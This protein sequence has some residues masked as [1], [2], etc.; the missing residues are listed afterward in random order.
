MPTTVSVTQVQP[1]DLQDNPVAPVQVQVQQVPPVQVIPYQNIPVGS[2]LDVYNEAPTGFINGI[3]A[4][5]T[6]SYLFVPET[7]R[8]Y[9]NGIKLKPFDEF[10]STG[11]NT[12]T[13][14]VS[15][16]VNDIVLIDYKKH[17]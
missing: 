15:P 9:V 4:V 14:M 11:M 16:E 10:T 7:L 5:F 1:I 17:T 13:L 8:V 3:N 2:L 12:I 6:S